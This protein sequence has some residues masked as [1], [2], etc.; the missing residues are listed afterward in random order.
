MTELRD[1]GQKCPYFRRFSN[2][3]SITPLND[4]E[5]VYP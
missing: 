2:Q 5:I 1:V 3:D 4:H